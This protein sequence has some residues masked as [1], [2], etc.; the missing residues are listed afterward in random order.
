LFGKGGQQTQ[1][2]STPTATPETISGQANINRASMQCH[3]VDYLPRYELF[4][5]FPE[6]LTFSGPEA[7]Q[8][9]NVKTSQFITQCKGDISH[10]FK[11]Q[12]SIC[13]TP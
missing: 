8:K 4:N 12:K 9:I 5:Q 3:F 7:Y 6:K 10:A 2:T 1:P 11:Q 13:L